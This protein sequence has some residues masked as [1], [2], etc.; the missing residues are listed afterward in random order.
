[1][2]TSKLLLLTFVGLLLSIMAVSIDLL[3]KDSFITK[4]QLPT[5]AKTYLHK[6]FPNKNVAFTNLKNDII[7]ATY[8]V[9]ASNSYELDFNYYDGML[10]DMDY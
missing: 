4:D 9:G 1:M 2:K 8:E 7:R 10:L 5:A 3:D 6:Y